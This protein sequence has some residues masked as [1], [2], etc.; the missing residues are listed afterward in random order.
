VRR[1]CSFHDADKN[2]N[3]FVG[4]RFQPGKHIC[5]GHRCFPHQL[6]PIAGF[7]EL[8]QSTFHLADEVGV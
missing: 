4:F 1:F 3:Q 6:Q 2:S 5:F 7:I 8:L